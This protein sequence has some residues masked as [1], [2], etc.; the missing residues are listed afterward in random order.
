MLY[1]RYNHSRLSIGYY[2]FLIEKI[3]ADE[4]NIF[5]ILSRLFRAAVPPANVCSRDNEID[6]WL[7]FVW[8][9]STSRGMA[10]LKLI[11]VT[12][13][14]LRA[15]KSIFTFNIKQICACP[16]AWAV[17]EIILFKSLYIS[18]KKINQCGCMWQV[19]NNKDVYF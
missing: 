18:F 5:P 6:R 9:I 19:S 12:I 1:P 4:W 8:C 3:V 13:I 10:L 16:F 7:T 2:M 11:H 17:L 14:A 15:G